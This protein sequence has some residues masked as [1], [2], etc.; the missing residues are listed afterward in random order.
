MRKRKQ[1]AARRSREQEEIK[2]KKSVN[3]YKDIGEM[4]K[5]EGY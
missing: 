1:V 2:R 4:C 3:K 5:H